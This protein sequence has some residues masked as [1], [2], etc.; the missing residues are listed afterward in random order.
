[1]ANIEK[2]SNQLDAI[3]NN[4]D[5][6]NH[7]FMKKLIDGL[8]NE[9]EGATGIKVQP[10]N[11]ESSL[12]NIKLELVGQK[13]LD[14]ANQEITMENNIRRLFDRLKNPSALLDLLD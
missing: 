10:T 3:K 5:N 11:K 9:I 8:S 1:M 13:K 12:G 2:A 14:M 6:S 4:F 7:T